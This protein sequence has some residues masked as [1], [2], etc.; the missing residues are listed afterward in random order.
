[1]SI[2]SSR[3]A[4]RAR[5]AEIEAQI[6]SLKQSI[7]HLE[8]EKLRTQ[9]RLDSYAYP[10]LTLPGEIT[11]EIFMK[12][13]PVYPS[14]SPLTGLLSPTTL[15]HVCH[16]WRE[17]DLSMPALWRAILCPDDSLDTDAATLCILESWLN[18]SGCLP[19]SISMEYIWNFLPDEFVVALVLHRARWEYVTL[20]VFSE[21]TVHTLQGAMPLL[22]QFEIRIDGEER[23]LSPVRFSQVPRLRSVTLW[24][25]DGPTDILPWSQ[26]TSLTSIFVIECLGPILKRAVNLVHCHLVLCGR[27]DLVPDIRLPALESLVLTPFVESDIPAPHFLTTL[28]T[29]SLRS[30]EVSDRFLQSD[31]IV[32]LN[33]FISKSGCRLQRLC[34]TGDTP[35]ISEEAYRFSISIPEVSFDRSLKDFDSYEK[36]LTRRRYDVL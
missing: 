2:A 10:I 7:L 22:R 28:I 19:L 5:I 15:T 33:S 36:T 30:R 3:A 11:A 1:M 34:I 18:R 17:I 26:L 35:S 20:A 21:R 25:F 29:L 16:E 24:E 9:E 31:P 32:L 4:D 6:L 13:V 27:Q 23:P 14:P 12:V 8:A